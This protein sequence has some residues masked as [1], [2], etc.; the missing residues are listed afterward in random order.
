[1]HWSG[2]REVHSAVRERPDERHTVG[3]PAILIVTQGAVTSVHAKV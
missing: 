2:E 3:Q 1:M